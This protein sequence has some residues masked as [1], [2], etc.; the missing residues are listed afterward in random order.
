M[1]C[2]LGLCLAVLLGACGSVAECD[3]SEVVQAAISIV[4]NEALPDGIDVELVEFTMASVDTAAHDERTDRYTCQGILTAAGPEG[5]SVTGP[6]VFLSQASAD[7]GRFR[8]DVPDVEAWWMRGEVT[9]GS[10]VPDCGDSEV[11]DRMQTELD[12]SLG[13]I[14]MLRER[15]VSTS[16]NPGSG[17]TFT[18]GDIAMVEHDEFNNSYTCQVSLTLDYPSLRYGKRDGGEKS[19]TAPL[20]FSLKPPVLGKFAVSFDLHRWES[21]NVD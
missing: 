17:Y 16:D 1:R 2:V 5:G 13:F 11:F 8:V 14:A 3:D 18:V 9:R 4:K 21:R 15:D 7:G 10:T 19:V 20:S 12:D 6:L